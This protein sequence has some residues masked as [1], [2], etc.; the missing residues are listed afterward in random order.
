MIEALTED[1]RLEIELLLF[2]VGI[3]QYAIATKKKMFKTG[4][5]S[6]N[7]TFPVIRLP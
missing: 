2:D 4:T 3:S 1:A 5:T 6:H 7:S